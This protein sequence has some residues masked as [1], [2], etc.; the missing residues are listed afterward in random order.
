MRVLL[1]LILLCLFSC[2]K[3]GSNPVEVVSIEQP[4]LQNEVQES[5]KVVKETLE[6]EKLT[7]KEKLHILLQTPQGK[8]KDSFQEVISF[9]DPYGETF[10]YMNFQDTKDRYT[11]KAVKLWELLAPNIA[12]DQK[13]I[14][15]FNKF[16]DFIHALGVMDTDAVG[17]S[18]FRTENGLIKNKFAIHR[19]PSDSPSIYWH[20]FGKPEPFTCVEYLP[21]DTAFSLGYRVSLEVLIELNQLV[22]N[23]FDVDKKPENIQKVDEKLSLLKELNEVVTG[24]VCLAILWNGQGLK[25]NTKKV[26]DLSP[27]VFIELKK[28]AELKKITAFDWKKYLDL[29]EGKLKIEDVTFIRKGS[30][31][32]LTDKA[33]SKSF[34]SGKL[35]IDSSSF[36]EKL[37]HVSLTGNMFSY[38][39]PTVTNSLYDEV[40]KET[41]VQFSQ[42]MVDIIMSKDDFN[43]HFLNVMENRPEGFYYSGISSGGSYSFLAVNG[44]S[45]FIHHLMFLNDLDYSGKDF[46]TLLSGVTFSDLQNAANQVMGGISSLKKSTSPVPALD[47]KDTQKDLE[48]IRYALDQYQKRNNG[49]YP[50]PDGVEGLQKLA[51]I[52]AKHLISE[53]DEKRNNLEGANDTESEVSYLYL[54][55]NIKK[56]SGGFYYPLIISKA[57][58]LGKEFYAVLANNK[59]V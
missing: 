33:G 59:I 57:G 53:I 34:S 5:K 9:L 45:S 35:L 55:S 44:V 54:G 32:I 48:H 13:T 27:A 47:P 42:D 17:L 24:E 58:I 11:D 1:L 30:Y 39:S 43:Y 36:K 15:Q 21:E 3:K 51:E 56:D 20:C 2:S 22:L 19:R 16:K 14:D 31:V 10:A 52:Q 26:P 46:N 25:L 6:V 37:K 8:S 38:L 49:F 23:S 40:L 18:H 28:G 29:F 50:S 7:D 4:T 12:S 41:S